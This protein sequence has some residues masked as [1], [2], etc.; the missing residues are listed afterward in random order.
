MIK[1]FSLRRLAATAVAAGAIVTAS[2]AANTASAESDFRGFD[3]PATT[4]AKTTPASTTPNSGIPGFQNPLAPKTAQAPVARKVF[5]GTWKVLLKNGKYIAVKFAGNGRFFLIHSDRKK[6][7]E[8]GFWKVKNNRLVML[9]VGACL[10]TNMKKCR[11][12]EHRKHVRVAFRI[13]NRNRV[14]APSGTF[15]RRRA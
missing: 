15:I 4:P 9:P 2:A 3:R 5:V 1:T 10:R 13:V 12:F 8:V 11:K 7:I 14:E 6:V